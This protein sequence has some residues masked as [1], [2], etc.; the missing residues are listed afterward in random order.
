VIYRY[1]KSVN[2]RVVRH[3]TV[4]WLA[5]FLASSIFVSAMSAHSQSTPP[6]AT[7]TPKPASV[8]GTPTRYLPNKLSRH[9][10]MYYG[11]IWGVDSLTV[12][13]AESGELIRFSY[14]VLDPNKAKP[15]N[16]KTNSAFLI[17]PAAG[18]RLSIPSLEKVG[19]L[20]QISTPE[21]GK[22]YWMAF[23]NPGR[24]VKRGDRVDIVIGQ[25]LAEDL[26]VE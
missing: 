13:A 7:S 12:K 9:A 14:Q 4:M 16:E 18:I 5:V 10:A 24:K 20:R 15:L 6:P 2:G 21:A 26:V 17:A 22:F 25:F 19:Q 1:S 3:V 8:A 11:A 23:S